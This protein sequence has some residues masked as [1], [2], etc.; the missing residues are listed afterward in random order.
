MLSSRKVLR[1]TKIVRAICVA[2]YV[3]GISLLCY[4]LPFHI[5]SRFKIVVVPTYVLLG[6]FWLADI[7]LTRIALHD[8]RLTVISVTDFLLRDIPRSEIET[9]KWEK[10]CR[11]ALR[12]REGTWLH[13]PDAGRTA[14]SVAATIRAWLKRTEQATNEPDAAND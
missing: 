4:Q 14:Q 3:A 2:I 10:G 6:A 11:A 9:V 7:F 13:L 1:P 8:D 12:L 5:P